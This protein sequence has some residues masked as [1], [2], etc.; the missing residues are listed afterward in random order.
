MN[1][2]R[3]T[4]K[5]LRLARRALKTAIR[6]IANARMGLFDR[7]DDLALDLIGDLN[8]S[9]RDVWKIELVA[10]RKPLPKR[11]AQARRAA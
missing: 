2:P 9:L 5:E 8:W 10:S 7:P 11:K 1:L 3:G 4:A 6:H